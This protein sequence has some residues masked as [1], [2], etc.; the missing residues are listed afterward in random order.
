MKAARQPRNAR[1]E[2]LIGASER[3]MIISMPTTAR[4][5]QRYDHRLRNLVQR[6]LAWR[7]AETF[8][9]VNSV[10][11]LVDASRGATPSVDDPGRVGGPGRR[12]CG[13]LGRRPD[14]HRS[15]P[16]G[17]GLHGAEVLELHD[18]SVVALP[19]TSVLWTP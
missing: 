18:R 15:A 8:A 19:E 17:L 16:P 4:P 1:L 13:C 2:E 14:H 5:Q 10:A 6:I 9:P 11:V 3:P 7:V 12:E